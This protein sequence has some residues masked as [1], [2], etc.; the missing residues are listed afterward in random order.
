MRLNCPAISVIIPVYNQEKYVGKCIRSVLEQS[1]LDFEVIIVN[2]GSTD[3]SLRICRKYAK[4]DGRIF[5][6]DKQNAGVAQARKDG[7]L[8]ACG[9]YICF[10]DSD[11]YLANHALGLLYG[12][13]IEKQSDVVIGSYDIV[14]DSWG[15][16]KKKAVPFRFLDEEIPREQII[17]AVIGINGRR[18]DQFGGYLWG[19]LYRRSCIFEALEKSIYSIF[20][21]YT[22]SRLIEDVSFNMALS[23]F[24]SSIWVSGAIVYHYR[25]GGITSKDFPAIRKGSSCFD[26]K[27][28][29]CFR[30]DCKSVL[31]RILDHYSILLMCDVICQYRFHVNSDK[32]IREWL[33]KEL[34]ERKI[35]LWARQHVH[36]IPPEMMKEKR[37]LA[38][39]IGDENVFLEAV[40]ERESF[41]RKHHYWKMKFVGGYQKIVNFI[42]RR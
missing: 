18:E 39:T 35:V 7:V 28:D 22:K 21:F 16:L 34:S 1:F 27:V 38:L 37:V 24:V 32:I 5:I 26:S 41:L 3:K 19:R 36:E 9:E 40:R 8:K 10:L 15:L 11:D 12:L 4:K 29:Y 42:R 2:D 17:P 30:Y 31:P 33:R 14:Y 13:A 23:P 6:I 25:Y 20:P